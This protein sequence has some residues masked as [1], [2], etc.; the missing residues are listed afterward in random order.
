ML[1]SHVYCGIT[2]WSVM[3][4][5]WDWTSSRQGCVYLCIPSAWHRAH[6]LYWVNIWKNFFESTMYTQ[7]KN[8]KKF[9]VLYMVGTWDVYAKGTWEV[10]VCFISWVLSKWFYLLEEIEWQ[11]WWKK[12]PFR[13]NW[14]AKFPKWWESQ[15]NDSHS[16][17]TDWLLYSVLLCSL[18][19]LSYHLPNS[20]VREITL[21][22]KLCHLCWNTGRGFFKA[23][24]LSMSHTS[25]ETLF[26]SSRRGAVVNE[27]D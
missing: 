21:Q 10:F 5:P 25:Q 26:W 23:P 19:E 9:V 18:C 14:S 11:S 15:C 20:L 24:F 16:E 7:E 4:C 6:I 1:L 22:V 27:S 3:L 2:T 12:K 17:K 13:H 8:I